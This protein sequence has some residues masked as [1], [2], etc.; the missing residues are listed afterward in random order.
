MVKNIRSTKLLPLGIRQR[1]QLRKAMQDPRWWD[2]PTLVETPC[3]VCESLLDSI[4]EH[5]E[6]TTLILDEENPDRQKIIKFIENSI[7]NHV[8]KCGVMPGQIRLQPITILLCGLQ[9]Y[10]IAGNE[11][12]PLIEDVSLQV[13]SVK[14]ISHRKFVL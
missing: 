3:P 14:C 9:P 4:L 1:A 13:N 8:K 12:I 2:A 5:P 10:W 7:D 6:E 11:I